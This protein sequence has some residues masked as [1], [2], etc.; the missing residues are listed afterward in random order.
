MQ[1][2]NESENAITQVL[3]DCLDVAHCLVCR[4]L[5]HNLVT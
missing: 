4:L 2:Q 1:L 5:R 3:P